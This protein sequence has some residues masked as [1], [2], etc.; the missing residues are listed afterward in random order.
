MLGTPSGTDSQLSHHAIDQIA[1]REILKGLARLHSLVVVSDFEGRI[2]WMSDALGSACGGA[3]RHVGHPLGRVFAE[4]RG[5][6]QRER[7][8]E[9]VSTIQ[10]HLRHHDV[11]RDMRLDLGQRDGVSRSLELSAFRARTQDGESVVVSIIHP[12]EQSEERDRALRDERDTLD[13][14]L[15]CS[16]DAVLAIDRF[17]F[18]S[19]ANS[20]VSGILGIAV[21]KL[22]GKPLALLQPQSMELV[23]RIAN[24]ERGGEVRGQALHVERPD[25][26]EIWVSLNAQRQRE[27]SPGG[28]SIVAYLRD[29]SLEVEAHD[30]LERANVE[31]ESYV[32][33]VSHDLRTPLV[34]LLGFTRL[35]R[36]DYDHVLDDTGRHFAHRIEQAGRSM[37]ALVEDLLELSRVGQKSEHPSLVDPRSVLLQ[38][39]AELKLSLDAS[40]TELILPES[41]P[42]VLCDR[43]CLYQIFSNLVGNALQ[44]MGACEDRRV[45]VRVLARPDHH[46]IVVDDRGPGIAE[47]DLER[48]FEV[49]HTTARGDARSTSTGMGLAIV[50]KIAETHG[51]QAWATSV[52]GEG[53]RFHVTL[54]A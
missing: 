11:L 1:T 22:V 43:T 23:Q 37:Q 12:G 34:S 48:I 38:L 46:E 24:L 53:A 18:I 52:L 49:F 19:Y 40:E 36:Q 39:R 10:T 28:V 15:E 17:G 4:L 54:P 27:P 25:G 21:E 51:G 31:L 16:P 29:A 42:L 35:L 47:T 5:T 14:M 26:S 7:L 32:H 20:G 3:S 44:H 41:P 9:Q 2:V 6:Q 50:R 33:S 8:A 45:R 13:R 30:Q